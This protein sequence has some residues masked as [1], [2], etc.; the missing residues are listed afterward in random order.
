MSLIHTCRLN[1]VNAFDYL[2]AIARNGDAIKSRPAMK[3]KSF[4]ERGV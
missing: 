4:V 3:S 2:M 1:E